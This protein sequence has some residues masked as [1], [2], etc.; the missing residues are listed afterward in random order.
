MIVCFLLSKLEQRSLNVA[1][2]FR[3][4]GDLFENA[5]RVDAD[6]FYTDE[7]GCVFKN[8]WNRVEVNSVL[9]CVRSFFTTKATVIGL[10]TF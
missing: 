8:I 9:H 5:P 7:N 6:I 4:D 1:A 3:V 2:S 10:V